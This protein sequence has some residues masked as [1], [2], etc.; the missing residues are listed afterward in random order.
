MK[1]TQ[2]FEQAVTKLYNA[3]HS[4]ELNSFDCQHCAVGNMCDN[5]SNWAK[6]RPCITDYWDYSN[7]EAIEAASKTGYSLEQLEEIEGIFCFHAP[8]GLHKNKEAQFKGLCEVVKYLCE[9]D[10]IPDVMDYTSLFDTESDKPV[11]QLQF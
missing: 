2:R 9:L 5:D 4:N 3:F 10:G 11:K 6:A 8:Y 1:T 7:I